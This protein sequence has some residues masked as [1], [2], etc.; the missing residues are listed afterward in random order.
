MDR[1]FKACPLSFFLSYYFIVSRQAMI[2]GYRLALTLIQH[3]SSPIGA[4]QL[5]I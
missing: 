4:R 3:Y 2:D 5:L 1:L